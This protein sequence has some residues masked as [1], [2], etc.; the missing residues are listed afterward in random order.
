M[1]R[2]EADFIYG[3]AASPSL[4]S[5]LGVK[6]LLGRTYTWKEES[7]QAAPVAMISE[8]LWR[9]RYGASPAVIGKI[10]DLNKKSFTVVGVLP[11]GF[12]FPF[13]SK[14]YDIWV[15]VT[16]DP[17][18]GVLSPI[19]D[20]HYLHAIARLRPRVSLSAAQA[21][22]DTILARLGR[23]Y[24]KADA[25]WHA[26]LVPLQKKF[27][28][29]VEDPLM[30][31]LGAVAFVVLIACANVANLLLA[32]AMSRQ[33]EFAVRAALGASR[34]R[35]IGQVLLES[36]LLSLLGGGLG[37]LLA[38]ESMGA[39]SS[40]VPANVPRI[41]AIGVNG[42]VLGFT[43]GLSLIAGVLSGMAAAL[44][45]PQTTLSESLKES[46]RGSSAPGRHRSVRSTLVITEVALAMVLLAGA[47]LLIRS[48]LSLQR[49]DPGFNPHN[50]LEATI[51]L[52][53]AQY[54]LLQCS[55][56]YSQL[57]DRIKVLP[58]VTGAAATLVPPLR[59]GAVPMEFAIEGRP[60]EPGRFPSAAYSDVSANY[61]RL[62]GIPLLRG[63][64]FTQDDRFSAQAVAI[65]NQAFVRRYFPNQNPIGRTILIH[66]PL[67]NM[68][69]RQIV[70]IVGDVR[71][72]RL[73]CTH[74]TGRRHSR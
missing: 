46:T 53:H 20:A 72:R 62:M 12:R 39:L 26:Q 8:Y 70:G 1:G 74:P 18:F 63:R 57:L 24:P 3:A 9:R 64:V 21:Q 4:F 68:H 43:I 19:R 40:L 55:A 31:L 65:V 41:H 23:T 6:P 15:P 10:I 52:P 66:Y 67:L 17:T 56:L 42:W 33:K 50:L 71:F 60:A 73:Q 11:S 14:R 36:G 61:F 13:Q 58:G 37:L 25:G 32:R 59:G 54:K 22:M 16:Q 47:G 27:V 7:T 38:F 35:L 69:A 49:V 45:R 5:I 30:I 29:G 48:F 2:G 28:G 51:S 44:Y 34:H